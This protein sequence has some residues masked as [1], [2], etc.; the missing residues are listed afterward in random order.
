[1]KTVHF[2]GNYRNCY[3][4]HFHPVRA[5][6]QE[7][8]NS[9]ITTRYFSSATASKI[10]EC[11]ILIFFSDGFREILPLKEKSRKASF[12][13]LEHF[14]KKFDHVIWFDDNDS[15]GMLEPAAFP[16]VDIYAKAQILKNSDYYTEE[17]LTGA[18]HRDFIYEQFGV[19]D[20]RLL[21]GVV[22]KQDLGK[23]KLA[24]NLGLV[25]W[26]YY[27]SGSK[28]GKLRQLAFSSGYQIKTEKTDIS[29]RYNQVIFRGRMWQSEPTV[30]WWREQT[31]KHINSVNAQHTLLPI[32][33]TK[34]VSRQEYQNELRN[35][36]VCPSPFGKGE[37]CYRDFESFMAGSILFK[38]DM[39]HMRTWP[40]LYL[41]NETYI[42]HQ[43]DFSDFD[44]K[45]DFIL[46]NSESYECISRN[47]Q[48]K[49][50]LSIKDGQSF[51]QYF[52]N[53]LSQI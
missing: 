26:N 28:L 27:N 5:F 49:F 46:S 30:G 36:I 16:L 1:M 45:L 7:L 8:L 41:D 35:S 15:S 11:D 40:D 37:I 22:T 39:R 3:T 34:T 17:H 43:W 12:D 48:S 24:W 32:D 4:R 52:S 10:Q 14:F 44:E 50:L 51:A 33:L 53:I 29:K 9:G 13:Y 23:L 42:S 25:N 47:G 20:R 31:L 18:L 38:P 21:K 19:E 6:K 2:L